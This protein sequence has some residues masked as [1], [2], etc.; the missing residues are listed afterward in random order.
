[1]NVQTVL[2]ICGYTFKD[3]E[4]RIMIED[5]MK[6]NKWRP[7]N[8]SCYIRSRKGVC[9]TSIL[10][11]GLSPNYMGRSKKIQNIEERGRERLE[12]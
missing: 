7:L 8:S 4:V 2:W 11:S 6:A 3:R 10:N 5:Q 12:K 9:L 1:M